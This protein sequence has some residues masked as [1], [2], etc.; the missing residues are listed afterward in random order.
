MN[1]VLEQFAITMVF[2]VLQMVIKDPALSAKLK[3]QLVGIANDIYMAWGLALPIGA[4]PVPVG[5]S[6]ASNLE[7]FGIMMILG[8][9]QIVIKNLNLSAALKGQLLGLASDI[10][11]A[12]GM[13][14]TEQ[15]AFAAVGLGR[16]PIGSK[17]S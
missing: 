5:V 16:I 8:T 11:A 1:S 2:G 12:Y 13:R 14:A 10:Y 17:K 9:L 6:T 15:S 4:T 3:S 7:N